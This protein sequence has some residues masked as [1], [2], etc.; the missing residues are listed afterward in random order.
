MAKKW[1]R[2][3]FWLRCSECGTQNYVTERNKLNTQKMEMNKYC[4]VDKKHTLHKTK[5]KL[6]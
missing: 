2:I 6:K 3:K 4:K 5:E 1:N